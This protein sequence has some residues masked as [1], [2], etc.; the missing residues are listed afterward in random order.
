MPQSSLTATRRGKTA[1]QK[2]NPPVAAVR[3]YLMPFGGPVTWHAVP[4]AACC[5]C[6]ASGAARALTAP[7]PKR[8]MTFHRRKGGQTF[9]SDPARVMPDSMRKKGLTWSGSSGMGALDDVVLAPQGHFAHSSVMS[10]SS[11]SCLSAGFVRLTSDAAAVPIVKSAVASGVND[12]D[13]ENNSRLSLS[14]RGL[15]V[16]APP[17]QPR[18]PTAL[19]ALSSR[20][21]VSELGDLLSGQN[22][23]QQE[24]SSSGDVAVGCLQSQRVRTSGLEFPRTPLAI[25]SAK[26]YVPT[27][28]GSVAG[29]ILPHASSAASFF[30]GDSLQLSSSLPPVSPSVSTRLQQR[31]VHHSSLNV[32]GGSSDTVFCLSDMKEE[33]AC[34]N[35]RHRRVPFT[36]AEA[37]DEAAMLHQLRGSS[38]SSSD[39]DDDDDDDDDAVCM[40]QLQH[41]QTFD[42]TT[43]LPKD[44]DVCHYAGGF[45]DLEGPSAQTRR[46]LLRGTS[47]TASLALTTHSSCGSPACNVENDVVRDCRGG[48][49]FNDEDDDLW[50]MN[51]SAYADSL[52]DAQ[53][54]WIEQQLQAKENPDDFFF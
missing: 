25:E 8:I 20:I 13:D 48:N 38:G 50:E 4:R 16:H 52:D 54:E 6:A 26:V 28:I 23:Q 21:E 31:H 17:F 30:G 1:M 32:A 39:V 14:R 43:T 9:P 24:L 37:M 27:T 33:N 19:S 3:E 49:G 35:V 47:S 34:D 45:W 18:T 53:V 41:L 12:G 22:A 40:E 15:S 2:R 46:F 36:D 7:T 10:P 11:A 5:H 51:S 42:I 44:V 29:G